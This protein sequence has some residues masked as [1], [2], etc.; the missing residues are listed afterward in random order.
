MT[1]IGLCRPSTQHSVSG[2]SKMVMAH[3]P[4]HAET[5][6]L[7]SII[8]GLVVA[9]IHAITAMVDPDIKAINVPSQLEGWETTGSLLADLSKQ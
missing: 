5:I 2:L 3:H 4:P 9:Q 1:E 8:Q 6:D 7:G